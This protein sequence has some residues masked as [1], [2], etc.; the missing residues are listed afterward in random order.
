MSHI[1][2]HASLVLS[3]LLARREWI[4][5]CLNSVSTP[6]KTNYF[7]RLVPSRNRYK[8]VAISPPGCK[9]CSKK[10]NSL[11]RKYLTR[12]IHIQTYT[13]KRAKNCSVSRTMESKIINSL[14]PSDAVPKQKKIFK[15]LSLVQYCQNLKNITPLET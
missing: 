4:K 12:N 6:E 13:R 10:K 3:L 5:C 2:H 7:R 11:F 9:F 14:P 15:R 8:D 1:D